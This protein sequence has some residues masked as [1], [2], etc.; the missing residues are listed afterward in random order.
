MIY[1]FDFKSFFNTVSPSV[2]YRA[3]A[4]KSEILGDL[5]FSVL[6]NIKYVYEELKNEAEL[7]NQ[8]EVRLKVTTNGEES[9]P[10]KTLIVR[11]GLPQGLSIS[12]LLATM[13]LEL[14]NT[15]KNLVMYADDGIIFGEK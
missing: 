11:K 4:Q 14:T 6:K 15:P 8:G 7:K 2:V 9:Y 5:I 10:V 13:T 12:P 3:L 1:E